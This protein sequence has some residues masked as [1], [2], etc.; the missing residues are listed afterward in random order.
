MGDHYECPREPGRRAH[1]VL[2]HAAALH[3]R[4]ARAS[5]CR[6]ACPAGAG[7][8]MA[9][10]VGLPSALRRPAASRRMACI[11]Y[12]LVLALVALH[13]ALPAR[14]WSSC[15]S[16]Q[17]AAPGPA[18]ALWTLDA[19]RAALAEPATA[20]RALEHDSPSPSRARSSSLPLAILIAWVLARTDMPGRPLARV[21]CSGSPSSCPRSPVTLG[22]ILLLDPEYGLHQSVARSAA[23]RRQG[24]VQHLLVLGHRLGPP[25]PQLHRRRR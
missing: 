25:R 22:W 2:L 12:T 20:Q 18:G 17:I 8:R 6:V 5:R 1:I 16:F 24:P 23:V 13:R 14:C 4:S 15:S 10:L 9:G 21:R 7:E 19:W 11:G 3:G